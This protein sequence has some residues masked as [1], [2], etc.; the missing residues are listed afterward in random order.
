MSHSLLQRAIACIQ[1]GRNPLPEGVR[2]YILEV[3]ERRHH[4]PRRT[5]TKFRAAL[6]PV[7]ALKKELDRLFSIFI[8]TRDSDENG[9][10]RCCTCGHPG[11]WKTMDC[12]HFMPRQDLNTRWDEKNC[13]LQCGSCNGFRGGEQLKFAEYIDARYGAGTADLL[14]AKARVKKRFDRH[15]LSLMIRVYNGKIGA[16]DGAQRPEGVSPEGPTP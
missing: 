1:T 12:G 8:R 13:A 14:R 9:M 11:H 5:T 3:L 15:A 2:D 7:P 6:N 4:K 10:G 16:P